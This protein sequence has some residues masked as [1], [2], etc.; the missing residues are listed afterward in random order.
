[1]KSHMRTFFGRAVVAVSVAAL[2]GTVVGPAFAAQSRRKPSKY[3][4]RSFCGR[5]VAT[6][7]ALY[8]PSTSIPPSEPVVGLEA[9]VIEADG[10][11]N[12]KEGEL[13][14]NQLGAGPVP[15]ACTITG[16][17]T[18]TVGDS[19][20]GARGYVSFDPQYTCYGSTCDP[21]T[22]LCTITPPPSPSIA[23]GNIQFACY[24]SDPNGDELVCTG[25]GSFNFTPGGVSVSA[26]GRAVT[27]R[28]ANEPDF[29][30]DP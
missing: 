20:L 18:Y 24:L 26:L 15:D 13:T 16:N 21:R 12:I 30:T 28:R 3:S 25:I 27:W 19:P 1:M 10:K 23:Q 14:E 5:Y 11:G 17:E 9:A 29:C 22:G 4:K 8:N 7:S 2:L 6:Y